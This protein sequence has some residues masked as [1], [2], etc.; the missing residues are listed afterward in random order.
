MPIATSLSTGEIP[1]WLKPYLTGGSYTDPASG[2]TTTFPGLL[3]MATA[4]ATKQ[5]AP[6]TTT[7]E[8]AI[9][10]TKGRI[11]AFNPLQEYAF[12]EASSFGPS[13]YTGQ[14]AGL[15]NLV[16]GRTYDTNA[17]KNYMNPYMQQVVEQQKREAIADYGRQLPQL[18]AAAWQ[19]GAGRGTRN[20]LMQAEANRNLQNNLQ[21][22]QAKGLQDAW[23]QGQQQFN[24]ETS[25]MLQAGTGLGQIGQTDFT[26]RLDAMKNRATMGAAMQ[27]QLQN[28]LNTNY[29]DYLANNR[30][31][32][33]KLSWLA[34]FY[35]GV[36]ITDKTQ[37]MF[38][39]ST[40]PNTAGVIAGMG[41]SAIGNANG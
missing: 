37:T 1:E 25:N 10:A 20:N 40:R 12:N 22:I 30:N 28:I 5:T 41:A 31:D 35:N 8:E 29:E 21:N 18:G 11:A 27:T 23:Q 16:G 38:S 34:D 33:S 13:A 4:Q 32:Y 36:P 39:P 19:A 2:Q 24:T 6:Y 26:Q 14:G 3:A 9:G 15:L 7:P 17:A